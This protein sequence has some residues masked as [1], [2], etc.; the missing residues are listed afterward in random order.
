MLCEKNR[1]L[2]L[3]GQLL[4]VIYKDFLSLFYHSLHSSFP[5]ILLQWWD[6]LFYN[7]NEFLHKFKEHT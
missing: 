4:T 3:S 5:F 1:V 2:H 7:E 6:Y